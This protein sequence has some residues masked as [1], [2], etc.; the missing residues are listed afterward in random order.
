MK[1][2]KIIIVLLISILLLSACNSRQDV[3]HISQKDMVK[4][5]KDAIGE[6]VSLVSVDGSE[7]R[8]VMTYVFQLDSRNITF[9]AT[10]I[11]SGLSIDGAQIGDYKEEINI[12]Y[13]EGIAESEYYINKRSQIAKDL[14]INDEDMEFGLAIVHVNNYE[15]INKISQFAIK[16]DKLY[17]FNEKKPDNII[18]IDLG[19]ISFSDPG[20]AIE[21]PQFSKSKNKRLK[22]NNVYNEIVDSYIKQL[23]KFNDCDN[24]IPKNI[25]NKYK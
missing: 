13:E 11:I 22:Y 8:D 21:G 14:N 23:K 12:K 10:S 3:K 9:K 20:N 25:C 5:V 2:I 4:Y 24:T 16:L 1:K 18:H 6:K 7:N 19:S 15:D 17:A